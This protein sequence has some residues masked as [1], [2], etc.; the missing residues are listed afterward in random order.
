ML[1]TNIL[2]IILYT[3]PNHDTMDFF[4][5]EEVN[6]FLSFKNV[7]PS[8][9]ASL[10]IV[11]PGVMYVVDVTYIFPIVEMRREV[12]AADMWTRRPLQLGLR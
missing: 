10:T 6:I 11:I 12:I 5:I 9:F 7:D 3:F 4:G 8:L 1:K 2:I